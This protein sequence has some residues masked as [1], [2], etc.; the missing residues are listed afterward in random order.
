MDVTR[1]A[2]VAR[3]SFFLE[4]VDTTVVQVQY[5][6]SC[7]RVDMKRLFKELFV[8]IQEVYL[9]YGQINLVRFCEDEMRNWKL[10]PTKSTA[11]RISD[12][13]IF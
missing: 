6:P 11:T 8:K 1:Q 10:S 13:T 3:I 4:S 5:I 2:I 12:K 7:D 9:T